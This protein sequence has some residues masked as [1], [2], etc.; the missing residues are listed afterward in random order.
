MRWGSKTGRDVRRDH[1]RFQ[2]YYH[3]TRC[4]AFLPEYRVWDDAAGEYTTVWLEYYE[5]RWCPR[6]WSKNES[7]RGYWEFR[8]IK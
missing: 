5:K 8:T 3:W 6:K 7:K 2:K 4:F 1:D